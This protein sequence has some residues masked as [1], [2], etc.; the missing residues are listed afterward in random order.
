MGSLPEAEEVTS[1]EKICGR[2]WE[3]EQIVGDLEQSAKVLRMS[4]A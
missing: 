1:S 4:E 3:I 2:K